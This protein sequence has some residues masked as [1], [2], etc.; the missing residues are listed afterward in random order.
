M[1]WEL[2]EMDGVGVLRLTGYLGERVVHRFHGAFDWARARCTGPLVIDLSGLL[3]WSQEGEAAIVD[4]AGRLGTDRSPLMLCG[5]RDR[6][7]PLFATGAAL[8][9]MR[10]CSDLQTALAAL[11][12]TAD[13]RPRP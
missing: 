11:G 9:L 1:Q 8:G 2:E 5:L 12:V 4:A 10:V 7:A 13:S 3:G 6:A